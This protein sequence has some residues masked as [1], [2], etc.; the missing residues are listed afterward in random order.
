MT[1][2]ANSGSI[3]RVPWGIHNGHEVCLFKLM[4]AAGSYVELTNY[5]ATLVSVC[6]PDRKGVLEN[7]VLGLPSLEAYVN[8]TCYIGATVGRVA[9]R[10]GRASFMLDGATVSLEPNDYPHTNHG[11]AAGFNVRVFDFR[12]DGDVLVFTLVSDDGEGGYPGTLRLDVLYS[13][14]DD[15]ELVIRY[16][17]V[18]DRKTIAN[19]TNHAYF[20]LSAASANILE[21]ELII[22]SAQVLE[23]TDDHIPTGVVLPAG[24]KSFFQN[25][26]KE[27]I[28][29]QGDLVTGVNAYYIFDAGPGSADPVCTLVE[30]VSAR[31]LE[32]FTSYPGVQLYTGDYLASSTPGSHAFFYKPFDGVCLECQYPPDSPNHPSFTSIVLVPGHVYDETIRFKFSVER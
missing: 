15:H 23:S 26:I 1:T 5:G 28:V 14:S 9:N 22:R 16:K 18:T 27:R 12:I 17:A 10:I 29:K 24:S 11:G 21:H 6:V 32:V 7:V 2:V 30:P 8:D 20:N 13:W 31:R 25:K 3:S 19:F 4:N